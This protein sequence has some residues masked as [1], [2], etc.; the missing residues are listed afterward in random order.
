MGL[1]QRE[2]G[3][4]QADHLGAVLGGSQIDRFAGR[5]D[6]FVISARVGV[7]GGQGVE[8]IEVVL[9]CFLLARSASFT[10]S[11]A[12]RSDW[13]G[14]VAMMNARSLS[15]SGD[16]DGWAESKVFRNSSSASF[17]W[18]WTHRPQART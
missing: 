15:D 18:P 7:G 12:F 17:A 2:A 5:G 10:A 3:L 11:A 14:Q 8:N 1:V 9:A 4:D 6:R 13:I 16:S